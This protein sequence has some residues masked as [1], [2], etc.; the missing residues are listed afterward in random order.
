MAK[1]KGKK[2]KGGSRKKS[3]SMGIDIMK[4]AGMGGGVF[5]DKKF[6]DEQLAKFIEDPMFRAVAKLALGEL[7]PKQKFVKD[8]VKDQS[9]LD[10]VGAAFAVTGIQELMVEMKIAGMG[11]DVLGEDDELAVL[12]DGIDD[13]DEDDMGDDI[14][15]INDD[16]GDDDDMGEDVLGEDDI[17]VIN[18]DDDDDFED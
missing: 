17:D 7:A 3:G 13:I 5:A 10:G 15:T 9:L 11:E 2:K 8:L 12:I 4:L 16:F 14:D 18:D 1:K 6:L